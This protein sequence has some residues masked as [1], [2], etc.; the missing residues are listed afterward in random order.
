MKPDFHQAPSCLRAGQVLALS[1]L[2]V[3]TATVSLNSH[4]ESEQ[5]QTRQ[6]QNRLA[7]A[8]TSQ[9]NSAV[10][11]QTSPLTLQQASQLMLQGNPELEVFQWRQ[12]ANQAAR[13]QA[14]LTPALSLEL[15]ADNLTGSGEYTDTSE[16]ELAIGLS[17]MLEL[18]QQR[19][20]RIASVD[21]RQQQ[22]ALQQQERQLALLGQLT[23]QFAEALAQQQQLQLANRQQQQAAD[24]LAIIQRKHSQG[25]VAEADVLQ[26][27]AELVRLKL[28][29]DLAQRQ[30]WQ[31]RY[32]V[33]SLVYPS[34]P[35]SQIQPLAESTDRPLQGQLVA[36]DT[37]NNASAN[38]GQWQ[39]LLQ[40]WQ[41]S[42]AALLMQQQQRVQQAR[43]DETRASADSAIGWNMGATHFNATGD[44]AFSLGVSVPLGRR[45]RNIS[46]LQQQ[47]AEL[48]ALHNQ[49]Q[50]AAQQQQQALYQAWQGYLSAQIGWQQ[51]Q[52]GVIPRLQQALNDIRTGY[53]QGRYDYS[54][55]QQAQQSLFDAQQQR[56]AHAL[57]LAIA[58]SWLEQLTAAPFEMSNNTLPSSAIRQT[59]TGTQP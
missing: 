32:Q 49:Q 47:Q 42:P 33:F 15:A 11:P 39:T 46:Q 22:W 30:L 21:A 24:S 4:A 52:Q 35:A 9:L 5:N 19:Q 57:D 45:S 6:A 36:V 37:S 17:S 12:Q 38:G 29:A 43:I 13:Q 18:G 58:R 26:A 56:I 7:Q 28:A 14:A 8:Q 3:L 59:H 20:R 10:K 51:Y 27:E 53:Q 31:A 40:Q 54:A 55:W 1:V 34:R 48:G 41:Q 44:V 23:R 16:T 25:A 50:T 2:F